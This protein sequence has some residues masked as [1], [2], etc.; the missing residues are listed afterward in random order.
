MSLQTATTDTPVTGVEHWTHK[1]DVRL[2]LWEKF[3]GS[4]Q[5]KPAVL[6]VHGS[7]M[8]SAPT[9]DL[10]VPGDA[11]FALVDPSL[12]KCFILAEVNNAQPADTVVLTAF[13][14]TYQP[15]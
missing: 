10:T 4:P 11:A 15:Q 13:Q 1:G 6:F 14:I 2:F 8:A 7:S 5:G 3:V 12:Y 9:F